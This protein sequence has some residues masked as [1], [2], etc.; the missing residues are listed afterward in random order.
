MATNEHDLGELAFDH[1]WQTLIL[2]PNSRAWTDDY[3]SL[4]DYLLL[5]PRRFWNRE[6]IPVAP[7]N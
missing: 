7:E 2:R 1:R 6:K 5:S 4:L 3:S